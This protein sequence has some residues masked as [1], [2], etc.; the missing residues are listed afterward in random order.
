MDNDNEIIEEI[1]LQK[2]IDN[3]ELFEQTYWE[4]RRERKRR[5][6]KIKKYKKVNSDEK[7]R[8]C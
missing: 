7:N 8:I 6:N 2:K 4:K 5:E 3:E 1:E